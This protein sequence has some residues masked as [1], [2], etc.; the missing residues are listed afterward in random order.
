MQQVL[1]PTC[2]KAVLLPE[3][4]PGVKCVCPHCGALLRSGH[5]VS[6]QHSAVIALGALILLFPA[7]CEPFLSVQAAGIYQQMSLSSIFTVLKGDWSLLLYVF[8]L[9]TFL[10]PAVMLLQQ[11][12]AG[13]LKLTPERRFCLLY[14][15]CHRFC[16]VDV[17]LFGVL[18]SLIKLT[19]LAEV[20]FH[21][22]FFLG[23]G[24]SFLLMYCWMKVPPQRMW[25]EAQAQTPY[26]LDSE[27]SGAQQG[28][29]R[30]RHCGLVFA[31]DAAEHHRCPRCGRRAHLREEHSR[32]RTCALLTA[33]MILY[34]PSNLYPIM[35][36]DYLGSSTGSN[37]VD[38]VIS[39]WQMDSQFVAMIILLASIFIPVFKILMLFCLIVLSCRTKITKPA[40]LS[41]IYRLICFIG[42]WSM[43]DVF[44]VII[45]S[46]A[47]R[48]TGLLTIS[49]GLAILAF[50]SVVLITMAAAE[51]FDVRLLWDRYRSNYERKQP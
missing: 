1:C 28:W 6:L 40:L 8:L 10:L 34:L 35:F 23:L 24:F 42:K 25:E 5:I 3:Y 38:G 26:H 2:D 27:R 49:P 13:I 50:C 20:G 9:F 33:S 47:V 15:F 36:T 22:G 31:S 12:M 16:L 32:S 30:C 44:V 4:S 48:I 51:M 41:L 11:V 29:I 45:M 18:V 14:Q 37:I 7:V 43:I 46:S 39:L 19:S 17:F 21:A